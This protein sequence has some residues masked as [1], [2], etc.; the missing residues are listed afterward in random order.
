VT[1]AAG[2]GELAT[3]IAGG[4]AAW[5]AFVRRYAALVAAAVRPL[6]RAPGDVEDLC[7]E[8]FLRLCKDDYR[9]LKSYDPG[10]A[11]LST[12][13][14]IVARS[15][16]RDLLRRRR[17]ESVDLESAPESALATPPV[18]PV[19]KL[20]FPDD[21]LSP[22]QKEVLTLLYDRDMEVAEVAAALAIDAQTVRS[23]HHKA[24]LKLR[25]HFG[26]KEAK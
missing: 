20:R 5:E 15:T 25:A 24:M 21:L 12:W 9:L 4:G 8:V 22:R 18:E 23:M 26:V 16:A 11:A 1:P 14:T 3:L 2:T 10:R 7:Q 19:E 6:A 13:L 17:I